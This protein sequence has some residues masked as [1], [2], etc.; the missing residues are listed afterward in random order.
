MKKTLHSLIFLTGTAAPVA[1]PSPLLRAQLDADDPRESI[2]GVPRLLPPRR[3][4]PCRRGLGVPPLW[5]GRLPLDT[6]VD[7]ANRLDASSATRIIRTGRTL[8]A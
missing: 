7:R 6:P 3:H 2:H 1:R 5:L 4:S 8:S